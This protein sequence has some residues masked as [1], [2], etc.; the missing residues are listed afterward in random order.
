MPQDGSMKTDAS[1]TPKMLSTADAARALNRQPQTLR[2]WSCRGNGP[3]LPRRVGG[4]LLWSYAAICL[5]L[6]V[7]K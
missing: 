2:Q 7:S 1:S 3:L 5:L 4:R 6:G